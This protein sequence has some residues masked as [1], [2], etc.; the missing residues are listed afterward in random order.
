MSSHFLIEAPIGLAPALLFMLVLQQL[1]SF[2]LVS[3]AELFESLVAGMVLAGV[4]YLANARAIGA[5]HYNFTT[6]SRFI[7]PF[8]EEALKA[9]FVIVLIARNRIGFMIDA[10]ILGFAVGA[11]FSLTEN[12]Y[13]LYL[14]PDANMG[15]WIVR[16]FGT[17]I[18]HGGA[19]AVFGVMAQGLTER[20]VNVNPLLM[21]P[22]LA[23]A[24]FVHGLY[25]YFQDRPLVAAALMIVTLPMILLV[26]FAKSEHKIHTWLLTDYESHEH[27]LDDVRNG[28]FANTEAGRF[29][30][31]MTQQFSP[32]TVADLL[33]YIRL[34]TELVMQAEQ[35]SL[36]REQGKK[37][38]KPAGAHE[39][40]ARLHALEKKIGPSAMM[41]IW[42]H[43][44]FSRRELF[45]LH[46]LETR[47]A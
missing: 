46:E 23:V 11:G 37:P 31:D 36:A 38:Q 5:L 10:A 21:L 1:D 24:V 28:R 39:A 27:L 16:G 33:A 19:T 34:H 18:M 45:E 42:P 30:S 15:V 25:N 44:H 4:A 22:G 7:A 6:Y 35:I 14:F 17:A 3:L 32:E 13:Y 43:L 41:A 26:V 47:A 9:A 29:I 2:K 8:P 12:L 20:Q 40:F